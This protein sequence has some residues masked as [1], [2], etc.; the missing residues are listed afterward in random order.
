VLREEFLGAQASHDLDPLHV[1]VDVSGLGISGYDA[2]D[3]LREHQHL[4]W[5]CPITA[6]SKPLCL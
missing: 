3:W 4:D 5:G 1:V 6:A 2:A